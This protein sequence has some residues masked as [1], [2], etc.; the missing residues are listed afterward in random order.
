[1]EPK[2]RW[3]KWVIAEAATMPRVQRWN[4]R[5]APAA[6]PALPHPAFLPLPPQGLSVRA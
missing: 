5:T 3:M 6:G 4:R 2:R 1:M